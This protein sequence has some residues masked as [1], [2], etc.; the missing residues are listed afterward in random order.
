MKYIKLLLSALVILAAI[1]VFMGYSKSM[2]IML[3]MLAIV[4][5]VTAWESYHKNKIGS[6]LL[7]IVALFIGFVSIFS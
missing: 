6:I 7:F 3:F 2:P 4:N 5:V 1:S